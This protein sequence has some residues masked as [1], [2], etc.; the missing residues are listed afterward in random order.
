MYKSP[1]SSLLYGAEM[2]DF[3][4]E[5]GELQFQAYALGTQ[6][7]AS[8]Y[9]GRLDSAIN[10]HQRALVVHHQLNNFSAAGS[11]YNNI[12]NIYRER[13][14]QAEAIDYFLKALKI[15]EKLENNFAISTVMGNLGAVYG[16]M[17]D[18]E[19]SKLW[20]NKALAVKKQSNDKLG[21]SLLYT[22]IGTRF[23][24]EENYD[25]AMYYQLE[26]LKIRMEADNKNGIAYSLKHIGEVHSARG[27][28]DSALSYFNR[29]LVRL[30]ELKIESGI[31]DVCSNLADLY[32]KKGNNNMGLSYA[33]RALRIS[34][35]AG[36]ADSQRDV[37]LLLYELHKERG[38]FRLSL[39]MYEH[40][41]MM[42][43]SIERE[44]NQKA[45][46]ELEFQYEY[47]KKFIAE[48]VKH[49]EEK[50]LNQ[51]K[52]EKENEKQQILTAAIAAGLGLVVVFLIFVFNRLRMTKKQ[53]EVI[54]EQ[55]EEVEMAHHELEEKN[56]E[57]MDS[58]S[59][60]KRIQSAIL[61][62]DTLVKELLP[63]SFILYKPKDIVAGDFYWMEKKDNI[64]L[65]AAAD[66]TGHGVP[67]A[68]VSVVCNNAM[69]RA[70]REYGLAIPGKILDKTREIVIEE[71]EKSDEEVKDGMD[72]ALCSI[73]GKKL[74]YAGAHNPLWI[75]RDGQL[76]ETKADKQPIGE[77]DN[78][79]DYTSHSYNLQKGDSIFIFSDGYV[80]QFGG[81]K[82]KKFRAKAFRELLL[83]IHDK[84]MSEQKVILD[85]TFENWKGN[86]EQIDD[87][88]VIG[89]RV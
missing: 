64:V 33:K 12:A 6:G 23:L 86:L 24:Y 60:A 62:S 68:M 45:T 74:Q 59:Y 50:K 87:V 67:G 22:G 58:I 36:F 75:I 3:A 89:V 41:I 53:K 81:E 13:G 43:D 80:D 20:Y 70:V 14:Q 65:F 28:L 54:E 27:E 25:S 10:F 7:S 38:E 61:P 85:E 16:D 40:H 52:H 5:T 15:Y 72:I 57:I 30:E 31:A 56:Q 47:D 49:E 19:H 77:F 39:E 63:E 46:I 42:R 34:D 88:C 44:A 11:S 55:K 84:S 51:V 48:G 17:G 83:S 66:C 29:S 2:Y 4:V 78:K 35:E 18:F 37:S 82:G 69:N 9:L 21:L 1:D 73:D 26:S 79:K 32:R 8:Y 76:L 71:F